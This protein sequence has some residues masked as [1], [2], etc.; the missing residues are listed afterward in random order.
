[1]LFGF[2]IIRGALV[3]SLA[4]NGRVDIPLSVAH[5]GSLFLWLQV[6]W[7]RKH[8]SSSTAFLCL[9]QL[10]GRQHGCQSPGEPAGELQFLLIDKLN[11]DVTEDSVKHFDV[12][13][14]L[15]R[16]WSWGEASWW[17]DTQTAGSRAAGPP[18]KGPE[19][20]STLQGHSRVQ[21][22]QGKEQLISNCL[23][24]AG[25]CFQQHY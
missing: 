8:Q 2:V 5:R 12:L 13:F 17:S 25:F 20:V 22:L 19:L 16:E 10:Q 3:V 1:M 4:G 11:V 15:S 18:Y 9:R 6:W 23:C 14:F 24:G 21:L 7:N